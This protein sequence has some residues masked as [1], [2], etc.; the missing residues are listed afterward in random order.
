MVMAGAVAA[1]VVAPSENYLVIVGARPGVVAGT[2]T[3]G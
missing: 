2:V 1:S 3:G